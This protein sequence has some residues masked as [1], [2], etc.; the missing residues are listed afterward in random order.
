MDLAYRKSA[1]QRDASQRG[2]AARHNPRAATEAR[3]HPGWFSGDFHCLEMVHKHVMGTWT[4][5][6]EVR[7]MIVTLWFLLEGHL[8]HKIWYSLR[9]N[10]K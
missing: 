2:A 3:E 10:P 5:H 4:I 6:V 7:T 9:P 8:T 1:A